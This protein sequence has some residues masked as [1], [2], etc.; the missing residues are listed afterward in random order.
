[1]INIS[2]II[3]NFNT[4]EMTS[5]CVDSFINNRVDDN[6]IEIII[7]DN[8]STDGSDFYF[9][10]KYSYMS[11]VKIIKNEENVGFGLANNKGVEV[12]QGNYIA[13]AN[14]DTYIEG[15]N[16]ESLVKCFEKQKNIGALSCKILYP[17]G[18]I[19]T[20]GFDFPSLWN[21]FKLNALFWNYKFMKKI[22]YH[23]YQN[24]GL[25]KRDWVSGCFFMC[26][27]KIF[28]EVNG[29]D[30]RI[31]MYAEDLD[32][33]A[34]FFSLG[35]QNYVYDNEEIYHLHG[36]SSHEKKINFKKL[37]VSKK[38]YYYVMRKNKLVLWPRLIYLMHVIHL[39]GLFLFKRLK[40]TT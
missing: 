24:K 4:K 29:F 20:L 18:T 40:Q 6:N 25:F 39:V 1:M 30:S 32:I 19:Q 16:F 26:E 11:N 10:E 8:A 17:N 31:F 23:N 7:V 35:N 33:C 34:R 12:A 2:I 13:F 14:S 37:L 9:R 22:R 3:V 21:D 15:L 38:N 36:K 27:K 28:Q 5:R